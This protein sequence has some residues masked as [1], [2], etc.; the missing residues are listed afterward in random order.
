MIKRFTWTLSLLTALALGEQVAEACTLENC[1]PG[2]PSACY[3]KNGVRWC[4]ITYGSNPPYDHWTPVNCYNHTRYTT[5]VAGA[6]SNWNYP[7]NGPTNSLYLYTDNVN[8]SS[9]DIDYWE[10]SSTDWWWGWADYPGGVAGNGCINRGAGRIRLNTYRI[11]SDATWQLWVAEHETG[12]EIGL[13]H[14]C[15]C[16]QGKVM[17]PCTECSSPAT[18]SYCD[19]QGANSLYH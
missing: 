5:A 2:M 7:P 15:G 1:T 9:H 11:S 10:A 8:N 19:G 16:S 18:L 17:N 4:Q 12:H 6:W 13:D 3:N 14:V